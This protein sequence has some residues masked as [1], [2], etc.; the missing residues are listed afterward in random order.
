MTRGSP[1]HHHLLWRHV[2]GAIY[3]ELSP[4]CLEL[5]LNG[6]YPYASAG[7]RCSPTGLVDGPMYSGRME[8]RHACAEAMR[9]HSGCFVGGAD[10]H[11]G[12]VVRSVFTCVGGNRCDRGRIRGGD[13]GKAAWKYK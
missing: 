2:A 12:V 10:I 11:A 8:R 13:G 7:P 9:I 4:L 3:I 5:C 6:C 1:S